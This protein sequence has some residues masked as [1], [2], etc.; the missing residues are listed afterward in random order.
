MPANFNGC[1][2]V[3]PTV[4]LVNSDGVMY[5]CR[6]L[7]CLTVFVGSV[8]DARLLLSIMSGPRDRASPSYRALPPVIRRWNGVSF[9]FGVPQ[10]KF[11]DFGGPG[12]SAVAHASAVLF[13]KAIAR[14][15]RLGGKRVESFDFTPFAETAAL[16]YGAPFVAERYSGIRKWLE[17]SGKEPKDDNRLEPILGVIM[18]SALKVCVMLCFSL[19]LCLSVCLSVCLSLCLSV[20]V[21]VCVCVCVCVSVILSVSLSLLFSS[22]PLLFFYSSLSASPSAT[23]VLLTPSHT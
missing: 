9:R 19:C 6:S 1:I 4:G 17:S 2:G 23:P 18:Q 10:D 3:K 11:L 5:A 16:L 8:E 12:G 21:W 20:S 7:D 13:K 22:S 14:L 15:E